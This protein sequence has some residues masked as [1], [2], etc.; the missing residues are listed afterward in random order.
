[1]AL[2][3]CHSQF[4]AWLSLGAFYA[5]SAKYRIEGALWDWR[6]AMMW[7]RNGVSF[8]RV[9]P[10]EVASLHSGKFIAISLQYA[11]D[12]SGG[13]RLHAKAISLCGL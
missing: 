9:L 10:D 12:F 7:N 4:T 3:L 8:R 5:A 11:L 2:V 6:V 13:Q 1:M